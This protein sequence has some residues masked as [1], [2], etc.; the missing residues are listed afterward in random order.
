MGVGPDWKYAEREDFEWAVEQLMIREHSEA[1]VRIPDDRGGDKGIDILVD[2]PDRRIVYQLK[3][4][5]DGLSSNEKTRLSQIKGSFEK[6]MKLTP[7]PD[8]WILVVPCK[9]KDSIVTYV[10]DKLVAKVED[11]KPKFDMLDQPKLDAKLLA[12]PD[13]LDRFSQ[14]SHF[15]KL[16]ELH[17]GEESVLAGGITDLDSRLRGLDR[18][19]AAQDDHWTLDYSSY[20]GTT[21]VTPRAKHPN[22]TEVSPLGVK[23]GI[24]IAEADETLAGNIRDVLG[25]GAP[26]EVVLPAEVVKDF[27]WFGPEFMSPD[28]EL[29]KVLIGGSEGIEA[30][31][32]KPVRLSLY[33]DTGL[34]TTV[35]EGLITRFSRGTGGY[36][37]TAGFHRSLEITMLVPFTVGNKGRSTITL[38]TTGCEP[39]EVYRGIDLRQA[40]RQAETIQIHL[41]GKKLS[42]LGVDQHHG[43]IND[44]ELMETADIARDLDRVQDRTGSIFA[45]PTEVS[46]LERIW[47]RV[48]RII[49]DGGIAP[50]PRRALEGYTH[51]GGDIDSEPCTSLAVFGSTV[52]LFGRPLQLSGPLAYFHPSTAVEA[53]GKRDAA[54]SI[55]FRMTGTDNTVFV[56]YLGNVVKTVTE[57]TP[58]GLPGIDEPPV[59]R[60]NPKK[61]SETS[62]A[63]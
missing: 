17:R 53:R 60:L 49:L 38:D 39:R 48:L 20:R 14:D 55:P 29:S 50:I 57:I 61:E 46:G 25:F 31:N 43:E 32:G 35:Q 21:I 12:N 62:K 28:G 51:P 30:L 2:Y 56:A 45:M 63:G 8:E 6:A 58:W 9:Y 26:G 13:L 54:G 34:E 52:Q 18:V 23:F 40:I 7:R 4:Y 42:T 37:I 11:P 59:P 15:D 36:S 10:T 41:D 1:K 5:T 3:F 33:D 27:T 22:A 24:D 47:L 16:V 44:S 19:V